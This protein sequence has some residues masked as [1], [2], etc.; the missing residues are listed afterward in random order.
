MARLLGDVDPLADQ[1]T[2]Q[3]FEAERGY[4]EHERDSHERV[5]VVV[6]DNLRT[7]LMALQENPVA[8]DA[9]RE[10]GRIKAELGIPLPALLHA[11]R[12]GGRFIWDR[13]LAAATD[14][15]A[16]TELLYLAS[17][18]WQIIDEHSSAAADSYRTTVE[19][20]AH[21]DTA[22]RAAMLTTLLDGTVTSAPRAAEIVRVLRLDRGGPLVVVNAEIEQDDG[23]PPGTATKLRTIGV[24]S[25]WTR[26]AGATVG[27]LCLPGERSLPSA[28]DMLSTLAAT[29][30]GV[31][32]PF[33]TP[34]D[35]TRA[36]R[37]A[38]V[39]ARCLPTGAQGAHA[40]GEAPVALLVASAPDAAADM[41][42]SVFA[43]L[44][45]LPPSEHSTLL[46]TLD[47]WF[48]AGGSTSKAAELL[49]CHRNTVLYRLNRIGELTGRHTTDAVGSAELYAA[50]RAVRQG[51]ATGD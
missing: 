38:Q 32:R 25:E 21:R 5:R 23:L 14:E 6:R 35:A 18:I 39:A 37:E 47:T 12:L 41:A 8:L 9:A 11:Y 22:A 51:A 33:R 7:L 27:L 40:Y 31:S 13:L 45:G 28:V 50:L 34:A 2:D 48:S 46:D 15:G 3:I 49:H 16:A 42:H 29:R 43:A 26:L 30:V 10:A 4:A 24:A 1:L 19:E 17:D 20:Q 36:W 44:N